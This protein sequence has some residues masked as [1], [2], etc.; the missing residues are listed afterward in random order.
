MVFALIMFITGY[1][2]LKDVLV[3]GA[4]GYIG[5]NICKQ[6]KNRGYKVYALD[7]KYP[8]H[9]YYDDFIKINYGSRTI[10]LKL[11]MTGY[12][13]KNVI[14]C[15]AQSLVGPSI[16]NPE[17]YYKNNVTELGRFLQTC[18]EVG[19]EDLVFISSAAVYYPSN[20]E[21]NEL[22]LTIP[23]NPYGR[24]KLIGEMMV[25]DSGLRYR[26]LR[27][28]NVCGSDD[29][30][31]GQEVDATHL[32]SVAVMKKLEET[33]LIINGNN[34]NTNDGTCVRDYVH[35][36]DI[37]NAAIMSLENLNCTYM[38]MNVCSGNPMSNKQ[39]ADKVGVQYEYGL[40][41]KGDPDTLFG[42]NALIKNILE[43]KPRYTLEQMIESTEKW[44]NDKIIM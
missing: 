28:F 23:Q 18:K 36:V 25:Q 8:K 39:I 19:V 24:T 42:S 6:L 20:T 2:M 40:T 22:S 12:N 43:W 21:L 26:N 41:R 10:D 32:I 13:I 16:Q 31:L 17:I 9:K 35:V 1:N 30:E 15:A 37:A 29:G 34:Y 33:K 4:A 44:Y 11:F 14:H 27:L 3:T 5:S 38:T 7:L